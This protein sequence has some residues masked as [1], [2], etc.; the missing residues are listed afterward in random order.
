MEQITKQNII[1]AIVSLD[2]EKLKEIKESLLK[3]YNTNKSLMDT[4]CQKLK[5][6]ED[7]GF[8]KCPEYEAICA[9]YS[10]INASSTEIISLIGKCT[11]ALESLNY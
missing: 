10:N 6:L 9:E 5:A 8:E 11:K 7:T 2:V 4:C 3:T 1:D